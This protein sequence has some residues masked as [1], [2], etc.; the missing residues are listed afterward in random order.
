[1]SFTSSFDIISVVP[2]GAEDEEEWQRRPDPN[3]FL[4]IPGSAADAAAVNPKG[5]K[6]LLDNGLIKGN[7]VFSNGPKSLPRNLPDCTILDNWVFDNLI[8]VDD[9]LAKALRRF[10]ACL[11]VN[12]NLWKKLVSPSPTIFDD[13]LKNSPVSFF[14]AAFN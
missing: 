3:I 7:P 6:T 14:I 2:F 4:C 8:S 11:L 13:N 12:H 1:M 10:S 9:L 5:I